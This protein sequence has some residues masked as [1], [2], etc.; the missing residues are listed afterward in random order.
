MRQ[1]RCLRLRHCQVSKTH[2]SLAA[3]YF[4]YFARPQQFSQMPTFMRVPKSLAQ[5]LRKFK[6]DK[7]Q[8]SQ[9]A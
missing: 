6:N 2:L 3:N 1:V 7:M 5:N 8:I 9:P 4:H